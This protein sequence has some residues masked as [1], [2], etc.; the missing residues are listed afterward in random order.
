[1]RAIDRSQQA[2]K[3]LAKTLLK[4][5][6]NKNNDS[7]NNTNNNNS[8]SNT[9]GNH[10][11]NVLELASDENDNNTMKNKNN[12]NN[13]IINRPITL[14]GYGMGARLI[15]HCLEE[16]LLSGESAKGII[17]NVVLMGCYCCYCCCC[18]FCYY[19]FIT[20]YF[21]VILIQ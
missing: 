5:Y 9:I 11:I 21:T 1:M 4:S 3:L 13:N 15:F 7:N 18:Y 20:L 2:G 16:L 12:N 14:I 10:T 17:E 19:N 8:N 6:N